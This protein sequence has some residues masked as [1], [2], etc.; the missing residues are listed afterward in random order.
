MPW[1][2]GASLNCERHLWGVITDERYL[3]FEDE[4]QYSGL[5]PT[6][7][8]SWFSVH[9]FKAKHTFKNV[10]CLVYIGDIQTNTHDA[11]GWHKY[12]IKK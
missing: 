10:P 9:K 3:E 4:T 7:L 1:T 6:V 5:T 11:N 2:L 8:F 12:E